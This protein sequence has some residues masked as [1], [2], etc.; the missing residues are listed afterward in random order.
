VVA[1]LEV[2]N[3]NQRLDSPVHALGATARIGPTIQAPYGL[4]CD[5]V[6]YGEVRFKSGEMAS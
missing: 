6:W 4:S 1:I 3:Q 5:P 2:I